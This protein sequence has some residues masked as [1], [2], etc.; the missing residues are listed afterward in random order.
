MMPQVYFNAYPDNIYDLKIYPENCLI[1]AVS[2][3]A[4]V[5]Q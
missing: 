4:Q 1:L 5:R 3:V 2:L